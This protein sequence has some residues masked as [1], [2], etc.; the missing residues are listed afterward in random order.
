MAHTI[1]ALGIDAL[2]RIMGKR[3]MFRRVYEKVDKMVGTYTYFM[4]GS[5]V[6]L[7]FSVSL[8]LHGDD[9]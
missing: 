9:L 3:P 5:W 1:Y 2:L 4:N 7:S 6:C 8:F